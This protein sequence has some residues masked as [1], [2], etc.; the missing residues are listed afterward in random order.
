MALL[1]L[2]LLSCLAIANGQKKVRAPYRMKVYA[3]SYLRSVR[4][5]NAADASFV[6]EGQIT[7]AYRQDGLYYFLNDQDSYDKSMAVDGMSDGTG[8]VIDFTAGQVNVN[9]VPSFPTGQSFM[10]SSISWS[11][12]YGTPTFTG[13]TDSKPNA[14]ADMAKDVDGSGNGWLY[15][16]WT[17]A[18][19]SFNARNPK[20]TQSATCYVGAQSGTSLT[21]ASLNP[22]QSIIPR[23]KCA[24]DATSPAGCA[25]NPV[26]SDIAYG[27][28]AL[29]W[30]FSGAQ[31]IKVGSI[32][33]CSVFGVPP[34]EVWVVGVQRF[35]GTFL[36]TQN[37]RDF[38]FDTQLAGFTVEASNGVTLYQKGDVEFVIPSGASNTII[39]QAGVDGWTVGGAQASPATRVDKNLE[40]TY[41]S[42][43]FNIK[44]ERIPVVFVQ[45]FVV[46]LCLIAYFVILSLHFAPTGGTTGPRLT[47]PTAGF[48]MTV[49][50]LF[51]AAAQVPILTYSTRLDK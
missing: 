24:C 29:T 26:G 18:A 33:T 47:F 49:S 3:Q 1:T 8:K 22:G 37:L 19:P 51:V 30:Y 20:A 32:L 50:F 16:D 41:S 28:D 2:L 44:L 39:P 46:P 34:T 48:G 35:G 38:P 6:V 42:A 11:V 4:K 21:C 25:V 13:L 36:Q 15:T 14:A 43:S 45:R 9:L 31:S 5:V 23:M 12:N 40:G 7:Y 27:D 17:A 10:Y